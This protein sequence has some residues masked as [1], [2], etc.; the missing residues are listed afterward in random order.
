MS[1]NKMW[2]YCKNYYLF[3]CDQHPWSGSF[4]CPELKL[5]VYYYF[6]QYDFERTSGLL[7]PAG[8]RTVLKY[9]NFFK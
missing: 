7:S 4:Q 5:T 9:A 2:A 8:V 1:I 6:P 3:I